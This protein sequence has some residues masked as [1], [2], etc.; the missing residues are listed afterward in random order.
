M[1]TLMPIWDATAGFKAYS[2]KVLE[3]TDLDRVKSNGYSF[4]IEMKFKAWKQKFRLLEI[5][6]VFVERSEG[7]SKMNKA[8]IREAVWKVVELRLRSLIGKL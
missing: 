7:M 2:R 4:Q 8:I 5:P 3:N 1:I 6:I